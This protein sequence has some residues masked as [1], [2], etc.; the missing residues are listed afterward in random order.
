MSEDKVKE[1][2]L[3]TIN[4]LIDAIVDIEKKIRDN[5]QGEISK[6]KTKLKHDLSVAQSERKKAASLKSE[7]YIDY[8]QEVISLDDY[9]DMRQRFDEQQNTLD[10][11]IEKFENEIYDL[12]HNNEFQLDATRSLMK[13]TR[14]SEITRELLGDLIERIVVD[15]N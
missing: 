15:Q 7:L 5:R 12:E 11:Q 3:T 6:I 2:L 8:K 10:V 9:K 1:I 14:V 4:T 13:Y